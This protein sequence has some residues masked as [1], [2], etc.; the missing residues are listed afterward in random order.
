MNKPVPGSPQRLPRILVIDDTLINLTLI[1]G[2]LSHEYQ[3][4]GVTSGEQGIASLAA[5]PFDLILLDIMM[6]GMD[7]FETLKRL[8]VLPNFGSTPVIFLTALEDTESQHYGLQLG[9]DDYIIKPFA[10]ELVR[11]RI[12]NLL[13]RASLQ[14]ELELAMASAH[15]GMWTWHLDSQRVTFEHGRGEVLDVPE[16]RSCP[17]GV[18]WPS[19]CHPESGL[20]REAMLHAYL[21]G[22]TDAFDADLQLRNR[23]GEWVWINLYGKATR[24][25]DDGRPLSLQGIYRNITR[26]KA[27]EDAV[28]R[29]EEQLR[30]VLEATDEG[31]WDWEVRSGIVSHNPA[32]CRI[33]GLDE[34]F[35]VHSIDFYKQMVH[36]ED[37]ERVEHALIACFGQ[38]DQYACEY[39]L[40]HVAGHYV[41]VADRG[42]VVDRAS[43]GAPLRMVGAIRDISE[44]KRSEAEIRQLAFHDTLTG[45]ANR[46]LLI[47]RLQQAIQQYQRSGNHGAL[48]FLDMDRFKQLNDTLGHD[49]GDMLLIEIARRLNACV[50]QSDTVSRLGGDEFVVLLHAI[51]NDRE[52]A[53][54]TAERIGGKMLAALNEPYQLGSHADYHSTPSIG[55][56][57]FAGRPDT[58]DSVLRRADQ[59]MYEAKQAGRNCLRTAPG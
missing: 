30:Y 55:V 44:R 53:A 8:R 5:A 13:R 39:R 19:V 20:I 23:R 56:T 17:E 24:H 2:I 52:Q 49:H 42:K 4:T 22:D 16:G 37:A 57:V 40:Q 43:D 15:L 50:R 32:W 36:R 28:R 58:P 12:R 48:L 3:V 54:Q 9:A 18:A 34:S 45:L 47:D 33:L 59:A 25:D 21:S 6:P 1:N 7:G 10:K 51:G 27:L 38:S 11:L 29:K 46:R 35:L 31:V 41:W 26:R 14:N